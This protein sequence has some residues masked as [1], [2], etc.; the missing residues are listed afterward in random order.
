MA[1]ALARLV[2]PGG[3]AALKCPVTGIPVI[4]A[5]FGFAPN[6]EHSPHLRFFS[7]WNGDTW[8]ANPLDLADEHTSYQHDVVR[9][10]TT[11]DT[12]GR[13]IAQCVDR[14]PSSVL[15]LELTNP[16]R[17]FHGRDICYAAFDLAP[18]VR[19]AHLHLRPIVDAVGPSVPLPGR[20][21]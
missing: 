18:A 11:W 8:A 9:I 6:G 16:L 19:S 10:L 7:D 5:T 4:S 13:S 17:G 3:I 1:A 2:I 20:R 14:M 21:M 12:R 15:V